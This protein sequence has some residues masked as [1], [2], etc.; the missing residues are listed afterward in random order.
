MPMTS[1]VP[2]II[3]N[4]SDS[5]L[6]VARTVSARVESS[7]LTAM[8]GWKSF[9]RIV[10]LLSFAFC[11]TQCPAWVTRSLFACAELKAI[12]MRLEQR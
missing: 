1:G 7:T 11:A 12:A 2:R 6:P 4:P 10:T 3:G 8:D 9:S 5:F